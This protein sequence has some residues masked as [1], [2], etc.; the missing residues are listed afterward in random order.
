MNYRELLQK[1]K[2]GELPEEQRKQ[3][4]QDIEKQDA[5]SEYLFDNEE[6][7][8]E[9]QV[10]QD[11]GQTTESTDGSVPKD[12]QNVNIVGAAV[13]KDGQRTHVI[14]GT[15]PK[16]GHEAEFTKLIRRAIRRTF[17]KY[18]V[19]TGVIVIGIVCFL[20]F[21]LP[22]IQDAMYYDPNKI[23]GTEEGNKTNQLSLDMSVYSELFLPENYRDSAAATGSGYGNYDVGG[24]ITKNDMVLYNPNIVKKPF[25]N[26]FYPPSEMTTA[27]AATPEGIAGT[28]KEAF[29]ELSKLEDE[30]M[31]HAY[32]SLDKVYSFSEFK[33]LAEKNDLEPT[34]C[35]IS[36]KNKYQTESKYTTYNTGNIGFRMYTS[37]SSLAFD[38]KKY[39]L[40]TAFSLAEQESAKKNVLEEK[41][42]TKH[43]T[44]MLQYLQDNDD[45]VK[46]IE[47]DQGTGKTDYASMIDSIQKDGLYIYGYYV[48][49]IGKE[50]KK[51]KDIGNVSY[52]YTTELK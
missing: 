23:V 34:W 46:M 21:A 27:S 47:N 7:E 42:V 40:L 51:L 37:C 10:E 29:D 16:D 25:S 8:F 15:V 13:P 49:D 52:V 22:K 45:I 38:Q 31:Y 32:V 35:A 11:G 44:S 28:K 20:V 14:E 3:V 2:A 36:V 39:P 30:K 12:G 48:E 4:R 17:I 26:V 6:M 19:I 24:R 41:D 9:E 1:Y 50:L 5:I 18:G 43:M 33:A